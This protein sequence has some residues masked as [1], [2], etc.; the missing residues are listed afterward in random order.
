M[1]VTCICPTANRPHLLVKCLKSYI[2]Q[3]YKDKEL[4]IL[5]DGLQPFKYVNELPQDVHYIYKGPKRKSI[6]A[7]LN[8]LVDE[9]LNSI[10]CR[11]DDDDV[12]GPNRI[13]D[14]L[15]TMEEGFPFVGY[16]T[17]LFYDERYDAVYSFFQ[18]I[19]YASGTSFMFHTDV[20]CREKFDHLC[21]TGSDNRFLETH[22]HNMKNTDG[23]KMLVARLHK[24]GSNIEV[25]TPEFL[26][27]WTYTRKA[28]SDIP[29][30]FWENELATKL[31][32]LP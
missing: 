21:V 6:G 13:S 18:T 25:K 32:L 27:K 30:F 29:P 22:H 23:T 4:I 3:D 28:H 5:D 26:K 31:D 2:S 8:A 15:K 1:K 14:Q 20:W 19:R 10:I 17:F 11:F 12:S 24:Q 16:H 9:S 7:K